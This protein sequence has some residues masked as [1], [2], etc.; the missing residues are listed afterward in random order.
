MD[1]EQTPTATPTIS[2]GKSIIT[3]KSTVHAF[4]FFSLSYE[5]VH[6]VLL[7]AANQTTYSIHAQSSFYPG[8]CYQDLQHDWQM[9]G[10]GLLTTR[11]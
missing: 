10:L 3:V 4:F 5:K 2:S 9:N 8:L 1:D 11:A 7:M 6:T